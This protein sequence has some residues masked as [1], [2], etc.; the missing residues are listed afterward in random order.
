VA[1]RRWSRLG[2]RA[3]PRPP[4]LG[5]IQAVSSFSTATGSLGISNLQEA[6]DDIVA[7][8]VAGCDGYFVRNPYW[9][10]FR[11]LEDV[12]HGLGA[13]YTNGTACHLDLVQWATD[14]TWG[15]LSPRTRQDLIVADAAFLQEQLTR[16]QITTIL[17]NG[18]SV[19]EAFVEAYAARLQHVGQV[20][21]RGVT[22]Q[23]ATGH[24]FRDVLVVGWSTN[25]QSS[26]GVTKVL[27]EQLRN[28]VALLVSERRGTH[29]S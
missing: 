12:L 1:R 20:R 9:R 28:T 8:I 7:R 24:V 6:S 11:P 23:L 21:D 15:G 22:A 25:L 2:M 29:Q 26:F 13:S 14:P 18:R 5:S 27:R 16:E 3:A 17:L 4:P 10:W 19:I